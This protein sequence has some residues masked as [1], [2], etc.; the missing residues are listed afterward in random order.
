MGR[1]KVYYHT[2]S[3]DLGTE[4][5]EASDIAEARRIAMEHAKKSGT[6]WQVGKIIQIE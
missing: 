1:F 2:Y 3:L 6:N 5:I 4:F